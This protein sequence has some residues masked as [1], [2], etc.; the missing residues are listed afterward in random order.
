MQMLNKEQKEVVMY[1][2]KWCKEAVLAMKQNQPV[3]PYFLFLS[4][5][6]G[7][8]KSCGEDDP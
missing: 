3:K 5:P 2:R 6:G 8:G 1:H 4:G 7:V